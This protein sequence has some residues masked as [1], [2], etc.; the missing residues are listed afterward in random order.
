M[1]ILYVRIK[2]IIRRIYC[3]SDGNLLRIFK[4]STENILFER[5]V[6]SKS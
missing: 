2:I 6:W 5:K 3:F 4:K 1:I